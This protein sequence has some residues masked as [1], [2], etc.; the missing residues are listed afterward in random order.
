MTP[1]TSPVHTFTTNG[2][3]SDKTDTCCLG[4]M[5]HIVVITSGKQLL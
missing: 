1:N 3:H 2:L 5:C 4:H